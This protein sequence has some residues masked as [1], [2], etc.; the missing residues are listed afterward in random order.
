MRLKR[1]IFGTGAI[2]SLAFAAPVA[3]ETMTVSGIYPAP[4]ARAAVLDSIAIE[5]FGGEEGGSLSITVGDRLRGVSIDGTPYFRIL[6]ASVARD[7]DAA[8]RGAVITDIDVER[9]SSKT[10][11][12]CVERDEHRKCVQRRKEEVP[13]ERL[14]VSV[15]P[16]LRLIS[17]DG[18]LLHSQ[19][20]RVTREKRYCAD[21]DQPSPMPM[22]R[23]AVNEIADSLRYAIAPVERS[24]AIRLLE[25]RK[26]MDR[27]AGRSFRDAVRMTKRNVTAACDA[28][29]AL[30]P[31][32]G[33]HVSLIFNL[34][35]CAESA[36]D[37][38]AAERY[39]NQALQIDSSKTQSA[40]GLERIRQ[41]EL[42]LQQVASRYGA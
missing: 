3:A 24:E 5:Q 16:S 21:E 4:N 28:F 37:F 41:R 10:V 18:E 30:E 26:G 11:S 39:Y 31:T 22:I 32:I 40:S 1:R 15:R 9:S 7:A 36:N 25:S 2:A 35:L 38:D 6:P 42:G 23:E 34:G 19:D 8:L 20:R 13:C 12:Q 27:D 14:L 29:S 33:D 17:V